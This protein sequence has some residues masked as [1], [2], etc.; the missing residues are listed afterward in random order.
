MTMLIQSGLDLAPL[1]THRF[2]VGEY[3]QAFET[4][5][6]GKSGKVILDWEAL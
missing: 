3:E 5:A 6:S 4:M 2:P 1:I